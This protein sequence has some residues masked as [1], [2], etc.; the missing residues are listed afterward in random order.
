ME[1]VI[2]GLG[3][4]WKIGIRNG[5]TQTSEREK[6]KRQM[7]EVLIITPES[8]HLLLAQKGYPNIFSSLN[9]IAV[10]EWHELLGS[11]RGVQVELAVSRIVGIR[12]SGVGSRQAADVS[13][14]SSGGNIASSADHPTFSTTEVLLTSHD[15]RLT[16]WGISAT[17]G[18]LEQAKDVLLAPTRRKGIIVKANIN[19][20][21]E[22]ESISP[23]SSLFCGAKCFVTAEKLRTR[24]CKTTPVIVRGLTPSGSPFWLWSNCYFKLSCRPNLFKNDRADFPIVH[25][26]TTRAG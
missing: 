16:L 26:Q 7:P 5:D 12:D 15:S 20:N 3:M 23:R 1:E 6:Q 10:D 13:G 14:E 11:K 17:I 21:I 19:K 22:I 4:Q 25:N 9:I 8:L 18:N 24:S 2:S